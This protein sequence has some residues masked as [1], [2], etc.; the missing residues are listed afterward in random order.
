ML[1]FPYRKKTILRRKRSW[2]KKCVCIYNLVSGKEAR[3]Y[4]ARVKTGKEDENIADKS[5]TMEL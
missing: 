2:E 4:R 1:I 5:T 3:R